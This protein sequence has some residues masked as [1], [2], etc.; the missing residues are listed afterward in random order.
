MYPAHPHW[1]RWT[2][3]HPARSH[4]SW[5]KG[6]SLHPSILGLVECNTA[7]TSILLVVERGAY[8]L[9]HIH[10]ASDGNVYTLHMHT[11]SKRRGTPCTCT[12]GNGKG[13]SL[14]SVLLVLML[15]KGLP[16]PTACSKFKLLAVKRDTPCTNAHP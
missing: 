2:G 5:W 16:V 3:I 13:H 12:A 4:S 11:A 14:H 9:L 1:K 8:T 15:G 10:F 6:Y 7:C